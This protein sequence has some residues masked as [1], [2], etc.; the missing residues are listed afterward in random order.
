MALRLLGRAPTWACPLIS[1]LILFWFFQ[2]FVG[3]LVSFLPIIL[4]VKLKFYL[5]WSTHFALQLSRFLELLSTYEGELQARDV[6]IDCLL[7]KQQLT[8]TPNLPSN[9]TANALESLVRDSTYI[10]SSS[11]QSV[12]RCCSSCSNN[13]L[14]TAKFLLSQREADIKIEKCLNLLTQRH[15]KYMEELAEKHKHILGIAKGEDGY[16]KELELERDQL[17]EQLKNRQDDFTELEEEKTKIEQKYLEERE[18]EKLLVLFLLEERGKLLKEIG[19]LKAVNKTSTAPSESSCTTSSNDSNLKL[20]YANLEEENK[21]L[22]KSLRHVHSE[23][24]ILQ[25]RLDF[26]LRDLQ[27]NEFQ[28]QFHF[29][30]PRT[31]SISE[32]EMIIIGTPTNNFNNNTMPPPFPTDKNSRIISNNKIKNSSSFPQTLDNLQQQLNKKPPIERKQSTKTSHFDPQNKLST[33]CHFSSSSSVVPQSVGNSTTT[34]L[35]NTRKTSQQQQ[36]PKTNVFNNLNNNNFQQQQQQHYYR[37]INVGG[38]GTFEQMKKYQQ[39]PQTV[40]CRRSTSL[41]RRIISAAQQNSPISTK[42][43]LLPHNSSEQQHQQRND[44]Y[45]KPPLMGTTNYANNNKNM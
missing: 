19:E 22:H 24:S 10:D 5:G 15:S 8:S 29:L 33:N 26:L 20:L 7:K 6:I 4:Y 41:P 16:I 13:L 18:R 44:F 3:V 27:Q 42:H 32:K 14:S 37:N 11:L 45:Q 38:G 17:F 9:S 12:N 34:M 1:H 36:Q 2:F 28:R 31:G 35:V 21:Q 43:L 23:K 25:K 39:Q 40:I 30:Q